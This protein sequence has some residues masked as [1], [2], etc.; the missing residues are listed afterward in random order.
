MEDSLPGMVGTIQWNNITGVRERRIGDVSN[1]VYLV[2]LIHH[3][4]AELYKCAKIV[5]PFQ[6][7]RH[8][9]VFMPQKMK[10]TEWQSVMNIQWKNLKEDLDPMD[11]FV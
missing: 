1:I 11:E 8:A 9:A 6:L 2:Q 5:V 4:R 10:H 7:P 3:W